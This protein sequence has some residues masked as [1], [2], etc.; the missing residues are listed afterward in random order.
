[1]R[2]L[3]ASFFLAVVAGASVP[4]DVPGAKITHADYANPALWLCR[5]DLKDRSMQGR[6]H[7]NGDPRRRQDID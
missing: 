7:R 2:F 3:I 5:P 6:S 1:M 4:A